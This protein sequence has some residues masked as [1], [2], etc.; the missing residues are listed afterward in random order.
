MKA[1]Q[2]DVGAQGAGRSS[3]STVYT[4]IKRTSVFLMCFITQ[5]ATE[6]AQPAETLCCANALVRH[7]PVEMPP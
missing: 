1:E 5:T 3:G 4:A 2:P 7:Q 6:N